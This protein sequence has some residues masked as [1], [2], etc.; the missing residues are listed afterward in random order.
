MTKPAEKTI[1][2]FQNLTLKEVSIEE[3]LAMNLA[4]GDIFVK[5]SNDNIFRLKRAGDYLEDDWKEKIKKASSLFESTSSKIDQRASLNFRLK[6]WMEV[7]DPEVFEIELKN[8]LKE[9]QTQIQS[10]ASLFDLCLS[11]FETFKPNLKIIQHFQ[12]RHVILYRRAHIVATLSSVF[13]LSCGYHDPRFIKDLYQ[14]AWVIDY[15]LVSEDF[16]YW[17]AL[18]CQAER[19][20]A[21]AG[22]EFLQSKNASPSEIQLFNTHPLLSFE[23][24]SEL[25]QLQFP[26]MLSSV[27]RHH[28]KKDGSGFPHSIPYSFISDWEAILVFADQFADFEEDE[29]EKQFKLPVRDLWKNVQS[30]PLELLPIARVIGKIK[31]WFRSEISVEVSS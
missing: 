3:V 7:E 26:E 2:S 22:L 27:V 21:G 11:F 31:R 17:V 12:D 30:Y 14:V 9:I 28:E 4:R 13:A 8:L 5:T 19:K 20:K 16:S 18:A 25:L 10:H 15:G 29:L 23:K 24:S 1:H 6:K